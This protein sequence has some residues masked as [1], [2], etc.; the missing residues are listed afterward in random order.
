M[1][2]HARVCMRVYVYAC[3]RVCVRVY[4]CVRVRACDKQTGSLSRGNSTRSTLSGVCWLPVFV[5]K[6]EQGHSR[7]FSRLQTLT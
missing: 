3:A 2:V 1:C 6:A 7:T 5:A 4:M